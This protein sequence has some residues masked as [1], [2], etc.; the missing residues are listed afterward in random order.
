MDF[1]DAEKFKKAAQKIGT[2]AQAHA[3]RAAAHASSATSAALKDAR[4]TAAN[5]LNTSPTSQLVGQ[6]IN[7]QGIPYFVESLLAEGGFGSIY[8]SLRADV[9]PGEPNP[10]VVLKRMYAGVSS[11]NCSSSTRSYA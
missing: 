10:A 5:M 1:F 9:A 4:K 8:K 6:T 7:I 11:L 3:A 2:A